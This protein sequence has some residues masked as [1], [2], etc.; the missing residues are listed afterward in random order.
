M[1]HTAISTSFFQE[2]HGGTELHDLC[3]EALLLFVASERDKGHTLISIPGH[4]EH[5]DFLQKP[6][7]LGGDNG[8]REESLRLL[9]HNAW[10]LIIYPV[11]QTDKYI[12]IGTFFALCYGN[13]KGARLFEGFEYRTCDIV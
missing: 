11:P 8:L 9:D 3:S 10:G 6:V 4:N 7:T 1:P 5:R 12:R 2:A 13:L